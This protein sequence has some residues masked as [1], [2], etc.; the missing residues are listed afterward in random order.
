MAQDFSKKIRHLQLPRNPT[1]I[2]GGG[3]AL[4]EDPRKPLKFL[5]FLW[6]KT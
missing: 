1:S 5:T 4:A 3:H 2:R 6:L